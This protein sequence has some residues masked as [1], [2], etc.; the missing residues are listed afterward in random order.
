[1]TLDDVEESYIG[2]T[3]CEDV[4][5]R[6]RRGLLTSTVSISFPISMPVAEVDDGYGA[7]DLSTAITTTLSAAISSGTLS[8]NIATAATSSS[9]S[10]VSTLSAA[11]TLSVSVA[12]V[13]PAPTPAS[14]VSVEKAASE[15]GTQQLIL[16]LLA[17]GGVLVLVCVGTMGLIVG[18]GPVDSEAS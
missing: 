6:V 9:A 17:A 5:R 11:T 14:T 12:V 13:T 10:S 2:D 3:T 8:S 15:G 7:S 4:N 18:G 16:I 1:M